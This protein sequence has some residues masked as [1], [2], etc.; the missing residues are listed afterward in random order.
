[1]RFGST[2]LTY[3]ELGA[4]A[5]RLAARLLALGAVAEEPI[6]VC[7]E[8]TGP[9]MV[10]AILGVLKSGAAFVPL[11][12]DWPTERLQPPVVSECGMRIVIA[13]DSF[14]RRSRPC[15]HRT[16]LRR[17]RL[18]QQNTEAV[19]TEAMDPARLCHLHVWFDGPPERRRGN[20]CGATECSP[21]RRG[22]GGKSQ[23]KI[24]GSPSRRLCLTSS[25]LEMLLPLVKGAQVV[26]ASSGDL[27]DA[28]CLARL[29]NEIPWTIAQATPSMWHLALGGGWRGAGN[30]RVLCG[31][32]PLPRALADHLLSRAVA[33]W[34]LYG[35]TEASIWASVAWVG[36]SSDEPPIGRPLANTALHVLG[37]SMTPLPV[38]TPGEL[39][40]GGVGVVRGYRNQPDLTRERF[41]PDTF[42][43][44]VGGRLY[45]TGDR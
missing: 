26:I 42:S 24:R 31:G 33:V 44:R 10:I 19:R 14:A 8:R 2:T 34:N 9:E 16:R 38:G 20:T 22:G 40:I 21:R 36:S 1:M 37:E 27:R 25:I 43:G 17:R 18:M 39:Y 7:I 4:A 5:D 35:P 32:E 29:L 6:G 28:R 45:R 23:A 12:P 3:R 30:Q 15:D 11:S 13:G 41:L